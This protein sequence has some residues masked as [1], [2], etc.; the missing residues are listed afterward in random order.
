MQE[1]ASAHPAVQPSWY[2]SNESVATQHCSF[3]ANRVLRHTDRLGVWG[4]AQ[5]S[6]RTSGKTPSQVSQPTKPL[7]LNCCRAMAMLRQC[8]AS[9]T[10]ERLL[11]TRPRFVASTGGWGCHTVT[12]WGAQTTR[13]T[14]TPATY[15]YNTCL[16]HTPMLHSYDKP[17]LKACPKS[18]RKPQE[19]AE[20]TATTTTTQ[21]WRED[22][23]G[24]TIGAPPPPLS[25][26]ALPLYHSR[27][28][29]CS[30]ETTGT[31]NGDIVQQPV[32]LQDLSVK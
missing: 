24:V 9:G 18:I 21:V 12:T 10:W 29:N 27:S 2:T 17:M 31:C 30:G 16:S 28:P 13:G 6:P 11:A 22:D 20:E 8:W 26:L 15:H 23:G 14:T 25:P 32:V 5:A 19:A 3:A 4:S 1:Q 7:S